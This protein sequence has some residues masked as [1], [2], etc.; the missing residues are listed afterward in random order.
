MLQ[1]IEVEIDASGHIHPLE[2]L[3]FPL[4]GR[5][6]LT[7]LD[8]PMVETALL[9]EA[10]LAEDWLKPEEDELIEAAYRKASAEVD[11]VWECAAGDGLSDEAW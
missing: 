7:L 8:R 1:T 3:A 11:P 4:A 6:L 10:A 5:A 9:A 2:P